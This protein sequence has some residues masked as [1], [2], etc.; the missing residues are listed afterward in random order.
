MAR[1]IL[2]LAEKQQ[3]LEQRPLCFI[4]EEQVSEDN[5]PEL[6]FD[7][8]RALDSGGS[9]ELTNFAGVHKKCHKGKGTKSLEDYK[10]ELRLDREFSSL[11]RFTDVASKLNPSSEKLAFDIDYP[12]NK[13]KFG[14]N[15]E[16]HL[17]R[18]P[19]TQLWYF[20]HRIPRKYLVSDVEVQPRGLEQKR[21]RDLTLNLRRNFQLSPTVCRLVTKEQQIK[22]F[23]GQHKATAQAV[24]NQNESV[25]C[26]IYI[27]PPLD[28]VRRVVVEGH[29]PLR[30]QEFKTSE[31][32]KKLSSNYQELLKQWQDS[33]PGQLISEAELPQAL[34]E[35]KKEVER[36]IIAYITESIIE[37]TNCTIADFVSKERKPGKY[38]LNYD[39]FAWWTKLLIKNPLVNE[40]MESDQNFR[41]DERKNIVKLYNFVTDNYLTDKWTPE[42]PDSVE[43]KK[44]RRLFYRASFREW[45]KLVSSSL[46]ILMYIQPEEPVFYREVPPEVWYKIETLCQ[47]LVAH[48]VW[49]DPN[50]LVETTLNSNVQ[51]DVFELFRNHDLN[52]QFL[53]T[54]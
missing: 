49:M 44:V 36:D 53:C 12:N 21:L 46:R 24:G 1:K 2:T 54:P 35:S 16:A 39:M 5:L 25:D 38:P 19:N 20:Y 29:G 32:F 31:L 37:D 26:K 30:Q 10:E 8:I 43:Y 48:P 6:D 42:N 27:D 51:K 41:E 17:H 45:T 34:G 9:N 52:P 23:D 11:F 7:H 33:H 28:M 18:C 50:P 4:C 40:P 47:K 3:V 15:S 22:V 14:D 13:V